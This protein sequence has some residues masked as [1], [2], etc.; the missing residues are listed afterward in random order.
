MIPQKYIDIF[1]LNMK[2]KKEIPGGINTF[3][4]KLLGKHL[5]LGKHFKKF[6]LTSA[7]KKRDFLRGCYL[8]F[9]NPG[10]NK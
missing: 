10:P 6:C 8:L 1:V 4:R 7:I 5:H 3:K 9:L 2:K